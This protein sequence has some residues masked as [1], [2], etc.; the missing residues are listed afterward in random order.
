MRL[1]STRRSARESRS[2]DST[3]PQSNNPQPDA[4]TRGGA[5]CITII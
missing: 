1:C 4:A 3:A 5:A 2:A